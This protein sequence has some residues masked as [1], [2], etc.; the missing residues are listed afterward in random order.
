MRQFSL[1]QP[2]VS[3]KRERDPGNEVETQPWYSCWENKQHE[4]SV[5]GFPK[6]HGILAVIILMIRVTSLV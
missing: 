4:R 1:T 2:K 3:L 6:K 5:R